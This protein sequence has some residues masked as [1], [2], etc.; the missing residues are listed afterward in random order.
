MLQ[1]GDATLF[2]NSYCSLAI[3]ITLKPLLFITAHLIYV[4][5]PYRYTMVNTVESFCI[6][7][8]HRNNDIIVIYTIINKL[9]AVSYGITNGHVPV[10]G[11]NRLK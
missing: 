6:T 8:K 3:E 1:S 4:Q 10:E 5:F 11:L 2:M 7:K 9:L